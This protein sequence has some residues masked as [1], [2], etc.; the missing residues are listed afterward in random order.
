MAE[1]EQNHARDLLLQPH[2][3]HQARPF[4]IE[5]S[6]QQFTGQSGNVIV[7][8]GTVKKKRIAFE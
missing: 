7:A 8:I 2:L 6:R 5:V 3:T 1:G 4:R